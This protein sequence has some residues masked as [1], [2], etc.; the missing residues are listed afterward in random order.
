MVGP[1]TPT[2]T[3]HSPLI[4]P[5]TTHRLAPTL[6]ARICDTPRCLH[7]L[8]AAPAYTRL[9]YVTLQPP[10]PAC[11]GPTILLIPATAH[12]HHTCLPAAYATPLPATTLFHPFR[13]A[14]LLHAYHYTPRCI[15]TCT[16]TPPH[17][18]LPA[19]HLRAHAHF[20][21]VH[22]A[23]YTH[24]PD[25]HTC[26]RLHLPLLLP[27]CG[28]PY[29]APP[30]D[31]LALHW[32]TRYLHH[33][34]PLPARRTPAPHHIAH[35]RTCLHC[36][37][38]A[39]LRHAARTR[40]TART[41]HA[42]PPPPPRYHHHFSRRPATCRRMPFMP[43]HCTPP[44]RR[45][46]APA[47][48]PLRTCLRT[49]PALRCCCIFTSARCPPLLRVYAAISA[50]CTWFVRITPDTAVCDAFRHAPLA[51]PAR[52]APLRLR[53]HMRFFCCTC[54]S[55]R[56]PRATASSCTSAALYTRISWT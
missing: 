33:H 50:H 19:Y 47:V 42:L 52:Y 34:L 40:A 8:P 39:C 27:T 11:C 49:L 51:S 53:S 30:C 32:M 13:H 54:S 9:H 5:H 2:H 56:S 45:L 55:V 10:S 24:T 44:H 23:A 35:A 16:L 37:A 41:P 7:H 29:T 26:L 15:R 20:C 43:P 25:R 6:P 36:T 1:L 46:H 28:L 21:H 22:T 17:A 3:T 14:Y 48:L 31:C 4:T 18:T 12:I 38:P